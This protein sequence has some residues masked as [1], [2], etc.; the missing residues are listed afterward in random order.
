MRR[1]VPLIHA[2]V[3]LM[4]TLILPPVAV[5]GYPDDNAGDCSKRL[6]IYSWCKGG[7][8]PS[9]RGFGYQ[10]CTDF[11][12]VWANTSNNTQS[13]SWGRRS[14]QSRSEAGSHSTTRARRR[15]EPQPSCLATDATESGEAVL[16]EPPLPAIG[17]DLVL[18]P[19]VTVVELPVDRRGLRGEPRA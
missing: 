8:W 17:V 13:T 16:Q 11:A 15:T 7:T 5:G 2:L 9:P 18:R 1:S 12:A 4:L 19:V 14:W 6:G 3:I 10:N